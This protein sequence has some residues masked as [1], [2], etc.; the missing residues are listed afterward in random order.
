MTPPVFDLEA[1]F[2]RIGW[3]G[4]RSVSLPTLTGLLQAHMTHIPFEALDVLLGRPVR[5]D[6]ASL[7]Q[8]LVRERRGGYCFE[9]T[10]LLAA[11]LSALGFAPLAHSA[12]VVLFRPAELAPRTHM[13]L[14]VELDEG[15]FVLDPGFGG[16]ASTAPIPLRDDTP[17]AGTGASHWM[18]RE[19]PRWILRQ[20]VDA[21]QADA[22]VTTLEVEQPVDFE[23]SNHWTSTHPDSPFISH[24]MLNRFDAHGRVSVMDRDVTLRADGQVRSFRLAD[25]SA[26]RALLVERFG[27]DLPEVETLRVPAIP[28][29]RD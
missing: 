13:F 27:F 7:Q 18:R 24:L 25:R 8:K 21:R 2:E 23:L 17:A 22:W 4:P 10:P 15:R 29:W 16:P 14:T 1:Y 19:G 12:R 5:L 26:L 20:A 6:L 9:Q 28:E 3:N 11:A